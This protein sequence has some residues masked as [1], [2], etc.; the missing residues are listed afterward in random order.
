MNGRC[1]YCKNTGVSQIE[2]LCIQ[3]LYLTPLSFP[4][5]PSASCD[6]A[7]ESPKQ[8]PLPRHRFGVQKAGESFW[9]RR[10]CAALLG[11]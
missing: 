4:A 3:Q 5:L 8:S 2:E 11:V 7:V 1:C 10:V 9:T 6:G